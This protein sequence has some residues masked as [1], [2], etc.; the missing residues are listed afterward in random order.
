MAA[1]LPHIKAQV[2]A[3]KQTVSE[4]PSLALDLAKTLVESV[5]KAV[6]EQ[7]AVPFDQADDLPKLLRALCQRL[8]FLPADVSG[9]VAVR[10]SIEKTLNGLKTVVQG[11]CELRNQCGFASH[12]SG[13]PK[14]VMEAAQALLAAQAAEAIVGFIYRSHSQENPAGKAQTEYATEYETNPNFNAFVD[15]QHDIIR[16]FDLEFAPSEVLFQMEVEGYRNY[17]AQFESAPETQENEAKVPVDRRD[18]DD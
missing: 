5:C 1:G 11:I 4:N 7:R 2:E 3:I 6:L 14:P 12:G 16:I 15:E 9:E 17:L 8:P 18:P 10:G 13:R